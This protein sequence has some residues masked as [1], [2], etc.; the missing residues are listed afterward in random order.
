MDGVGWSTEREPAYE[1]GVDLKS[2]VLR[3]RILAADNTAAE[4]AGAANGRWPRGIGRD[5]YSRSSVE[6]LV[7][8]AV[9]QGTINIATR[10][11]AI[12]RSCMAFSFLFSAG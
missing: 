9:K 12:R 6:T 11:E 10:E 5:D 4:I 8:M 2:N 3:A 7:R 1:R